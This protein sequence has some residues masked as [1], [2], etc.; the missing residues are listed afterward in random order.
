MKYF[1]EDFG[2]KVFFVL[3]EGRTKKGQQTERKF[4]LKNVTMESRVGRNP[5]FYYF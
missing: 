3:F 2:G 4:C 5:I 1:V